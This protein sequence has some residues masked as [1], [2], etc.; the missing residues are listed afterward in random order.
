MIL[1]DTCLGLCRGSGHR[2]GVLVVSVRYEEAE[3]ANQIE[4]TVL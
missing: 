3:W 1:W 2:Q 4:N